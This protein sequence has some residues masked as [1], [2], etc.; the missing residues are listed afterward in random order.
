MPIAIIIHLC[1][2]KI[3][4]KT[5]GKEFIADIPE[6]KKEILNSLREVGRHLKRYL[7]R[8]AHVEQQYIR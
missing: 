6:V 8:Q 2:T 1:S 7:S 4:Y 3:P 5:V